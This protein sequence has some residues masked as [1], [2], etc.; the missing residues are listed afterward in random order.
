MITIE[1]QGVI[2]TWRRNCK[3]VQNV[4]NLSFSIRNKNFK[5]QCVFQKCSLMSVCVHGRGGTKILIPLTS[6]LNI[7]GALRKMPDNLQSL[8][9]SKKTLTRGGGHTGTRKKK[10]G[11]G[12]SQKSLSI[13]HPKKLHPLLKIKP[14]KESDCQVWPLTQKMFV[15][16]H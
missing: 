7:L 9:Q 13:F 14:F 5:T 11:H 15:K 1:V 10:T 6:A 12:K 16:H 8:M 3:R 4:E 2:L